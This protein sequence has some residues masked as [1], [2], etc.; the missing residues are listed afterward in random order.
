MKYA[1]FQV[2]EFLRSKENQPKQ[3]RMI[4]EI[5]EFIVVVIHTSVIIYFQ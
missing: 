1:E 3:A 2:A 4:F 5:I